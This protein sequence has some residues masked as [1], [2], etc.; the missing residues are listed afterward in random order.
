MI[1]RLAW[2]VRLIGWPVVVL[3]VA[4]VK[5]QA[6]DMTPGRELLAFWDWYLVVVLIVLAMVWATVKTDLGGR[7]DDSRD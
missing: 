2:R 5:V 1:R 7:D 6:V 3:I 4:W